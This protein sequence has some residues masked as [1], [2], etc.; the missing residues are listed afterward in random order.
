MESKSHFYFHYNSE[1]MRKGVLVIKT[2][3]G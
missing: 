3:K 2:K 1:K